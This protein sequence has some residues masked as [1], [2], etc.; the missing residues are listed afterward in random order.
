MLTVYFTRD[1]CRLMVHIA[2]ANR[3]DVDQA[4]LYAEPYL[5]L[6]YTKLLSCAFTKKRRFKI[7]DD[8]HMYNYTALKILR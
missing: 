5:D 7:A 8:N 2:F 4:D 3:S 6:N 1:P